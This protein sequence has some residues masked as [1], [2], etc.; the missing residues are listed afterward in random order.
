M[1]INY[2]IHTLKH[3]GQILETLEH[4]RGGIAQFMLGDH[5][6]LTHF[7]KQ[8]LVNQFL[9]RL[10]LNLLICTVYLFMSVGLFFL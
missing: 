1:I 8:N 6:L 5:P 2:L 3:C 9:V 4:V 10:S 7:I